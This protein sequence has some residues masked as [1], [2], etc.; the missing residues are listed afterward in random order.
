MNGQL[1]QGSRVDLSTSTEMGSLHVISL[2]LES[3]VS[4]LL[5]FSPT[6]SRQLFVLA[7]FCVLLACGE[8]LV[9][10]QTIKT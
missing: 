10:Y 8:D 6:L 5:P 4:F 9:M 1:S 3:H 7:V 2:T